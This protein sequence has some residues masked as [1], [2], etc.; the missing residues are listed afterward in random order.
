MIKYFSKKRSKKNIRNENIR[1]K[2][3]ENNLALNGLDK[4]GGLLPIER[5]MGHGG[6]C[7]QSC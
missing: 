4:N 3:F 7:A 6:T 5:K 2:R 1:K